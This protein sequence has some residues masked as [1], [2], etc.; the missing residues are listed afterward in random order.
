MKKSGIYKITNITTN[1][2]YIG[3]SID[4]EKRWIKHKTELRNKKHHNKHL[5][6]LWHK[7]GE[8][9][10]I[11]EII[12]E[13][14]KIDCINYEQYFIDLLNPN[15]NQCKIAGSCLGRKLSKEHIEK[16]R[17]KNI[18]K[19]TS[20]EHKER[21]RQAQLGRKHS[22]EHIEKRCKNNPNIKPIYQYD[23]HGNFIK[24]WENQKI[25]ASFFNITSLSNACSGKQP[26]A[27]GYIWFNEFNEQDLINR[28]NRL[29]KS[30][31]NYSVVQLSLNDEII[32]IYKSP[33]E[34]KI[35]MNYTSN[36]MKNIYACLNNKK[37][38]AYG[39]KWEK[40]F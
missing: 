1:K 7:Y 32:N 2:F 17:I 29:K 33:N 36:N 6:R 19:K 21:N 35:Q 3:S 12:I 15:I 24:K 27:C 26:T 28:L 13:C 31:P 40:Q 16:I 5:E 39:Y 11:F 8:L 38:S 9:D 34:V 14:D 20:E 37:K 22:K 10:F 4:I 30:N 18:V 25:A 23:L